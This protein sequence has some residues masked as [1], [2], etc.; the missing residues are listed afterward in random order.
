MQELNE[1]KNYLLTNLGLNFNDNQEKELYRKLSN[2]SVGFNFDSTEE[3]IDWILSQSLNTEQIEKLASFLTIG[4]TYFFREKKALDYLE[5]EY[6][7]RLIKTRNGNNNQLKIWSAG[8]ASGEEPYSIAI[9]LKRVIP[10]IKNWD[11]TILATD[12]NSA[13][14]EKARRGVYTKWSFRGIPESFKT[15]YFRKVDKNQYQINNVIKKMVTFSYLNLAIDS[16]PSTTNNTNAFD[17]ILC[18]NVLIYFSEDGIKDVTSKFSDS[19]KKGGVLITSPVEVSPLISQKFNRL[20]YNGITIFKKGPKV[21]S[22]KKQTVITKKQPK[23]LG[24]YKTDTIETSDLQKNNVTKTI[25]SPSINLLPKKIKQDTIPQ[26]TTTKVPSVAEVDYQ[27]VL[28]LYKA[29]AFDDVEK[30]IEPIIIGNQKDKITY[31]LLL[32][33]I[34]AN[35]GRLIESEKLCMKAINLDKINVEAH[36]LMAVVLSEQGKINEAKKSL[37][38]TIFLN[39]DFALGHF[40]LGNLVL[41]NGTKSESKKHFDNAIIS[42]NKLQVEEL[43]AESDGLTGL[44]SIIKSMII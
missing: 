35:K 32:A 38:K 16:Y 29:G 6:L 22:R 27:E 28:N 25:I 19:L 14:L 41:G 17:I 42:L 8:C 26:K 40:M 24:N 3:F 2:A 30:L 10:D 1:I 11:I 43:I 4:E 15:K 23:Q 33:R 44:L 39:P 36:Y 13:F 18:R 5:F 12:V 20:T 21:E 7:P 31:M 37:N 34:K 9:L